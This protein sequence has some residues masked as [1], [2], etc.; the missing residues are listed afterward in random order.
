[1]IWG[2]L[3][4]T[5]LKGVHR[6][7]LLMCK[8]SRFLI[9]Q[10][11]CVGLDGGYKKSEVEDEAS[12]VMLLLLVFEHNSKRQ[13]NRLAYTILAR[14]QKNTLFVGPIESTPTHNTSR[15]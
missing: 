14:L 15:N 13:S 11:T 7:S 3:M 2:L 1:M 4:V 9:M 6:A 8:S 10:W 12:D 5:T